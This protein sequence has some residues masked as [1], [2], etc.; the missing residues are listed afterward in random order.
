[1]RV[2]GKC[3]WKG[4]VEGMRVEGMKRSVGGRDEEK[5][6]KGIGNR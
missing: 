6:V 4:W 1:M 3:G 5:Y 2:G